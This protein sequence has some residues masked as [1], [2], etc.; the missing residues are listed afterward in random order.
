MWECERFQI[1]RRVNVSIDEFFVRRYEEL[2]TDLSTELEEIKFGKLLDDL[3]FSGIPQG[4]P[5]TKLRL[6]FTL[7]GTLPEL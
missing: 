3:E 6:C 4:Q 1:G 2:S 7:E 5:L